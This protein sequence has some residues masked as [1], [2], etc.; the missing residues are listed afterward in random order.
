MVWLCYRPPPCSLKLLLAALKHPL[1]AP[2]HLLGVALANVQAEEAEGA[3][4]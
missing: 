1:A 4:A 2:R 3:V